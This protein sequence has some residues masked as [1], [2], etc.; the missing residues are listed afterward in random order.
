MLSDGAKHRDHASRG[1]LDTTECNPSHPPS[2]PDLTP[3]RS[4]LPPPPTSL[5]SQSSSAGV[6][7]R[8]LL[9]DSQQ[10]PITAFLLQSRM[11]GGEWQ[12][13]DVNIDGS[14]SQV[15][16]P[17]LHKVPRPLAPAPSETNQSHAAC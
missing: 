11:D 17:G 10:P 5:S 14:S 3:R 6:V 7:L 16:V 9:P 2:P 13:V 15:L 1:D 4:R 8:W 12:D